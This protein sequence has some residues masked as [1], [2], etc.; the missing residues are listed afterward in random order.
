RALG[1]YSTTSGSNTPSWCIST[2]SSQGYSLAGVEFA[3][4]ITMSTDPSVGQT[5]ASGDC[6]QACSGDSTQTCGGGDR[7][8]VYAYSAPLA[9]GWNSLGCFSDD[10][11]NRFVLFS[12]L[13]QRDLANTPGYCTNLCSQ[14]GYK[15]AGVEFGTQC[16]CSNSV[17]MAA[18][19]STG[20]AV[21]SSHCSTPCAGNS[22]QTCGGGNIIQIF[23]GATLGTESL[24][25]VTVPHTSTTTLLATTTTASST[26]VTT[27]GPWTNLGCYQDSDTR[28]LAAYTTTDSTMTP[29]LCQSTCSG[30]GY[31]YAGVEFS[32]QCFCDSSLASS[33][34]P[35]DSSDCGM[36][37]GGDSTQMCGGN[38]AI[39]VYSSGSSN[40][41]T[42]SG[43]PTPATTTATTAVVTAAT[44][45]SSPVTPTSSW[46]DLGCYQDS[47]ARIL[48][49]YSN[50]ASTL[51][52]TSC[53]NTCVG[54]GYS[55]AGVE[56]STECYC[57]SSLPSTAVSISSSSCSMTC[58][59]DPSQL[60]GG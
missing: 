34:S 39:D 10:T 21:S 23:E 44:T 24:N 41:Q 25:P 45:S 3:D 36:T 49:G 9:T 55:Y 42:V 5:E 8:S 37:C 54:M 33:A 32:T 51:T 4:S 28:V 16:F 38:Y 11:N 27:S 59:G 60:C 30:M 20:Q 7:I 43:N 35:I 48:T 1:S 47:D 15:Y 29:A 40:T 53:Q 57:G 18:S 19:P 26:P 52:P 46:T 2:C 56:F 17:T 22:F 6:S 14:Q 58:G 31:S 13:E 12:S 50:T